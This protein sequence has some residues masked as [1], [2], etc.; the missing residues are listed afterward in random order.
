MLQSSTQFS[1]E[2]VPLLLQS[3]NRLSESFSGFFVA[4][5]LQDARVSV[6]GECVD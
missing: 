1:F 3:F 6:A 4:R 2:Y 5:L